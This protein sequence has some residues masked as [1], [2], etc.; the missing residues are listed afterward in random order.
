MK[1][2]D[3]EWS[4]LEVLWNGEQFALGDVVEQLMPVTG[5]SRNTVFT[6]LTR[7]E[8]K[9][10]VSIDRTQPRPYASAVRRE[11]CAKEERQELLSRVYGGRTGDLVAAFLKET[12]ISP[13]ERDHLKAMLDEMEV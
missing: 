11:D 7:M 9:G 13:E 6:Y 1:I 2:T 8:K 5:W 12:T 10:L 4:V 3:S